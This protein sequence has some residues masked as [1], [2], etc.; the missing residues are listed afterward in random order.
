MYIK[1]WQ[2]KGVSITPHTTL[3]YPNPTGP[4]REC[5][6][7]KLQWYHFL[8]LHLRCLS[9]GND[10]LNITFVSQLTS[11]ILRRFLNLDFSAAIPNAFAQSYTEWQHVIYVSRQSFAEYNVLNEVL[12]N[13]I[14][15]VIQTKLIPV[16][17]YY[18]ILIPTTCL[19][20]V[21]RPR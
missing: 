17:I 8:N 21:A 11:D 1:S 5:F 12:K 3:M 19:K 9:A 18:Y 16:N 14:L 2:L 10:I 15:Y 6:L 13:V 7:P 20:P 4:D